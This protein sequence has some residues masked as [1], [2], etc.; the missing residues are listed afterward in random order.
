VD[1]PFENL[2]P[3]RFQHFCQ[4]LLVREVPD[5]QCLPVGQPDGGRDAFYYPDKPGEGFVVYQVKYV[6]K[7]FAEKDIH[8]WLTDIVA[9]EAPKV[10]ELI[11]RGA[12]RYYLLTN[13]PGTA[14]L[15][16]GSIDTLSRILNDALSVPAR[17]W[18]RDDLNS[19]LEGTKELKWAYPELMT[20][21]DALRELVESGLTEDKAR[22]TATI[23]AFVSQQYDMDEEV[24]FKQVDLQNKLLDLF[25]DVPLTLRNA[26][27]G[28]KT[29]HLQFYLFQRL[30]SLEPD[31]HPK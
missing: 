17:C 2:G 16:V 27:V 8:K 19:R 7:P 13:V 31:A 3:E 4:A 6:R 20:G 18:W 24:K 25:V 30:A 29:R 22:R 28:R 23:R 9:A 15:D 1:H 5:L 10:E 21:V 26:K 14:H 12:Q 11:K